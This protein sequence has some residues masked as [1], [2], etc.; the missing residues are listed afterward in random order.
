MKGSINLHVLLPA[1]LLLLSESAA[2]EWVHIGEN[3]KL[4]AYA[5]TSTKVVGGAVVGWVL[6]DY[7]DVQVSPRSG[8]RYLSEKVQRETDCA[9]ER[10]R[11]IFFTWH[12]GNMGWGSVIYTGYKPTP[13]E[14]TT[15]PDSIAKAYYK[16]ACGVR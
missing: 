9:G 5:D 14:P 6:F 3:N 7:K 2:A 15:A 1:T 13:W 11:A 8:R 10:Q 4:V 12:A 16:F